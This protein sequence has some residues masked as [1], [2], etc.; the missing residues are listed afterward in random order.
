MLLRA[1]VPCEHDSMPEVSS[2]STSPVP[3]LSG[4]PAGLAYHP[5][6]ERNDIALRFRYCR[7]RAASPT[8]ARTMVA[9]HAGGLRRMSTHDSTTGIPE[10][11]CGHPPRPA[12][13]WWAGIADAMSGSNRSGS[14][15]ATAASPSTA[16]GSWSSTWGAPTEPGSTAGG[17]IEGVLR[18]GDELSIAHCRFHLEDLSRS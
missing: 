13:S 7:P 5:P 3:P 18:P 16:T 11:Q 1:V 14:R 10:R 8:V 2:A 9:P 4:N 6:A 15:G 12:T 17:S